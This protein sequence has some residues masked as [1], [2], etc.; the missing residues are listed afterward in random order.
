MSP[1]GTTAISCDRFAI[2]TI[3]GNTKLVRPPLPIP[4]NRGVHAIAVRGAGMSAALSH[5]ELLEAE[6][7]H[8]LRA[9]AAEFSR[10]CMLC[11]VGKD[12]SVMLGLAQK[13]FRPVPI[14]FPLLHVATTYKFGEMIEFRDRTCTPAG[15]RLI[16]YA[17][18]REVPRQRARLFFPWPARAMGC[19]ELAPGAVKPVQ[20]PHR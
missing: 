3:E 4:D 11:S 2:E 5:L 15:V 10:P 8:I 6:S 13:A 18:R 14:P 7:I 12:S 16:V 19:P 17:P 9:V 20:R 1:A